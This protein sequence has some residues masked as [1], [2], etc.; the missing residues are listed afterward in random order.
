MYKEVTAFEN[1]L[2]RQIV[3]NF[4]DMSSKSIE[5]I[6]QNHLIWAELLSNFTDIKKV[7]WR[8]VAKVAG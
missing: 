4:E 2:T 6:T 7:C 3:A 5:L 8:P 1:Y